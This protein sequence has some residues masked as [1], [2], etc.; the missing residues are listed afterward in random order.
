MNVAGYFIKTFFIINNFIFWSYKIQN[1][2]SENNN[3]EPFNDCQKRN[4][5]N[6]SFNTQWTPPL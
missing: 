5:Y 3:Y 2:P 6:F 4:L 1:N